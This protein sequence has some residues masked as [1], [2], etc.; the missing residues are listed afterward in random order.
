MDREFIS[1]IIIKLSCTGDLEN[2]N[3]CMDA[4]IQL[5]LKRSSR[6]QRVF[7]NRSYLVWKGIP[8][9]KTRS[10]FLKDRDSSFMVTKR[11]FLEMEASL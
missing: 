4:V 2:L 1:E 6:L 11:D 10:N 7:P 9:P 5:P 3:Q 8:P